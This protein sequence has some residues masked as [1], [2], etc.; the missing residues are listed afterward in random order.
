MKPA[1]Q[2]FIDSHRDDIVPDQI[3]K[4]S[5]LRR[6]TITA[7]VAE[8]GTVVYKKADGKLVRAPLNDF[9][10]TY[11]RE[12]TV[13]LE[14]SNHALRR[15]TERVDLDAT[16][17]EA[18]KVLMLMLKAEW[19]RPPEKKTAIRRYRYRK[20]RG[21]HEENY[22]MRASSPAG[23][24]FWVVLNLKQDC[25]LTVLTDEMFRTLERKLTKPG[26]RSA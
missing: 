2:A 26:R 13:T 15:Y 22:Y 14:V 1:L 6:V 11:T 3:W 19:K 9:L 7:P 18:H 12:E 17:E 8:D 4:S 10:A 21:C 24:T 5:A 20:L 25:I 23:F 16:P